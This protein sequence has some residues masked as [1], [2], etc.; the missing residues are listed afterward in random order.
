MSKKLEALILP[1]HDS[2]ALSQVMGLEGGYLA[3]SV[4]AA[5]RPHVQKCGL[6]C[7]S[8]PHSPLST[9]CCLSSGCG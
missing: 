2:Q 5:L 1:V 8:P 6:A 7:V 3:G 9:P 4:C